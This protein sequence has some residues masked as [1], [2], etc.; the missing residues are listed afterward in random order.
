VGAIAGFYGGQLHLDGCRFE[1]NTALAF[2]GAVYGE[3]LATE[4]SFVGNVAVDYHGGAWCTPQEGGEAVLVQSTFTANRAGGDG[5]ALMAL[6]G[7]LFIHQC[8][9]AG[10][11]A[12]TRAPGSGRGGGL[13]AAPGTIVRGSI[14]AGNVAGEEGPDCFGPVADASF[15]L[16]GD[17]AGCDLP[18]MA[19]GLQVGV[20]PLLLPLADGHHDLQPGS[21][22]IDAS[23][24]SACVDGDGQPLLLDALGRERPLDGDAD[25]LA[26]C[27]IGAVETCGADSDGDGLGDVCD[28]APLEPGTLRPPVELASLRCAAGASAGEVALSWE[29][30]RGELGSELVA[31]VA[32]DSLTQLWLNDSVTAPCVATGLA[33]PN[34]DETPAVP[35][36][37]YYLVRLENACG[38]AAGTGWGRDSLDIERAACP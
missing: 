8:T 27:D 28:C 38:P 15:S 25:G 37:R 2:G 31:S 3:G 36:S 17:A 29:D 1:D 20:D 22:A 16:I 14:L 33:P 26:V 12:G 24:P 21:P 19:P 4:C 34:W 30:L 11:E 7:P 32:A 18:A 10:N 5:G 6:G 23:D 35:G 9:V 13:L